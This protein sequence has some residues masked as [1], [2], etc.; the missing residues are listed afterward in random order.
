[1]IFEIPE[2]LLIS[3][4]VSKVLLTEVYYFFKTLVYSLSIY[5]NFI[6]YF[7]ISEITNFSIFQPKLN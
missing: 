2:N 4:K 7:V 6:K 5:D 3:V 1:M